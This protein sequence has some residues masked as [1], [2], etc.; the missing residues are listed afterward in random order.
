[1]IY[2]LIALLLPLSWIG[3]WIVATRRV[4][5]TYGK[6]TEEAAKV[7]VENA[8]LKAKEA[9]HAPDDDLSR[10]IEQ[11]RAIGRGEQEP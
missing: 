11:M 5:R 4:V 10:R 6:P 1:M 2:I 7:E 9:L 8:N 3:L